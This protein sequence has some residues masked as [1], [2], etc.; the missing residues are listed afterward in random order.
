MRSSVLVGM[1]A[2][3]ADRCSVLR[4]RANRRPLVTCGLVGPLCDPASPGF[5]GLLENRARCLSARALSTQYP[6][7][8]TCFT[9]PVEWPT[10]SSGA[11][12]WVWLTPFPSIASM[13]RAVAAADIR[14]IGWRNVVSRG[15]E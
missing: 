6:V 2:H 1:S 13:R 9:G 15:D 7:L 11:N 8:S 3:V 12:T 5:A 4:A 14:S 10:T